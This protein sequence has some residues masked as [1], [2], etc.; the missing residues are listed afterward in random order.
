MKQLTST[1]F[2]TAQSL[3]PEHQQAQSNLDITWYITTLTNNEPVNI[4]SLLHST[5]V[6]CHPPHTAKSAVNK[7]CHYTGVWV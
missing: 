6:Y 7:E 2:N 5:S 1:S 4:N 3:Q